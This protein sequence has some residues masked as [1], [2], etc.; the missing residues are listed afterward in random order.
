MSLVIDYAKDGGVLTRPWGVKKFGRD[1]VDTVLH[2]QSGM[3]T[4]VRKL[5]IFV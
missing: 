5:G 2:T 3:L 4:P 1:I